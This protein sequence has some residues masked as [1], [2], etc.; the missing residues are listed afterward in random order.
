MKTII[1]K[2]AIC[3]LLFLFIGCNKT[4]EE[5][6]KNSF[7]WQ[8]H[9]YKGYSDEPLSNEHV[10]LEA[11]K[12]DINNNSNY[13]IIGE[14]TTDQNGYYSIT[15]KN[16]GIGYNTIRLYMSNS[17]YNAFPLAVKD[18]NRNVDQDIATYDHVRVELNVKTSNPINDTLYIAPYSLL[19]S[20]GGTRVDDNLLENSNGKYIR[21][22]SGEKSYNTFI[23]GGVAGRIVNSGLSAWTILYGFGRRD[24][25]NALNSPFLDSVPDRYNLIVF[26][27]KGF[28]EVDTVN[29]EL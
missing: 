10:Y 7:T 21:I 12:N 15:Y 6:D 2:I 19:Q 3:S 24:F 29:I 16:V 28:P 25:F 5:G 23:K 9:I 26:E 1:Q 14:T 27:L 4:P 8:G 22:I 17:L 13:K 20:E 18:V 11:E